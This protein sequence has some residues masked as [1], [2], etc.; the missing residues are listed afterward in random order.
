MFDL[1][2]FFL[3]LW[4]NSL[5][6]G[7]RVSLL[8]NETSS[9]NFRQNQFPVILGV[10]VGTVIKEWAHII[11]AL[12]L[13]RKLLLS[14]SASY[15]NRQRLGKH[16]GG[17]QAQSGSVISINK[18]GALGFAPQRVFVASVHPLVYS[19]LLIK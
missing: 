8:S 11:C 1:V 16:N 19:Q 17:L 14:R 2:V 9:F 6:V 15:S 4:I 13:C 18:E 5:E 3:K 12:A 10:W 7:E